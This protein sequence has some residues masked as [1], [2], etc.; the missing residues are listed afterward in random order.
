MGKSLVDQGDKRTGNGVSMPITLDALTNRRA[1]VALTVGGD[2]L[3]VT[4][5]PARLTLAMRRKLMSGLSMYLPVLTPE[6]VAVE[7]DNAFRAY[8]DDLATVLVSWDIMDGKKPLE[9]SGETLYSL[10][11]IFV[12]SLGQEVAKD[13]RGNPQSAARLNS[14]SPTTAA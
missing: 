7:G 13:S 2:S 3:S 9:I 6:N 8:C 10:D 14:T 4:Y 12:V 5:S 11:D 1:E